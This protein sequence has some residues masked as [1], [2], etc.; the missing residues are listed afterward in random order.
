MRAGDSG[1]ASRKRVADFPRYLLTDIPPEHRAWLSVQAAD[2]DIS[3]ADIIRRHLCARYRLD[4]PPES[5]GYRAAFDKQ[6]TTMVL[7]LQPRLAQRL[8][9][10]VARTGRSKRS[11][12][13][14]TI[15]TSYERSSQ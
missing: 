11:I 13:L 15:K 12:I 4:C 14:D 8:E 6:T 5:Y 2:Q 3:V 1:R 7:R 9:R 10:D